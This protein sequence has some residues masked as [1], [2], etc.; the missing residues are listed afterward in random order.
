MKILIK[1]HQRL[2]DVIRVLA[3]AR[4]LDEKGHQVYIECF[5]EYHSIFKICPYAQ[6]IAPGRAYPPGFKFDYMIDLEIWPNRYHQYRK[7]G[8]KWWDF[9]TNSHPITQGLKWRSPF[10]EPLPPYPIDNPQRYCVV[11]N[12]GFSQ[13][14]RIEP[15]K[16]SALA[17][18]LYP[19]LTTLCLGI[20]QA[21]GKETWWTATD[22]CYLAGLIKNAGAVVTINTSV[23][24][25]A[26]ALRDKYDHIAETGNNGQDDFV[27]SK[28]NRHVL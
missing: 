5:P 1:Y 12:A 23:T 20:G 21:H 9:V 27:S 25:F 7:S 11:A 14:P 6:P 18:K 8:K 13:M 3:M 17:Q 15:S 16:V 24:Y 4:S 19:N 2:G 28:Q 22:L 10:V 26:D